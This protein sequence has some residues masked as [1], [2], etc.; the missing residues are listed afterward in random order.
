MSKELSEQMSDFL[1]LF[2]VSFAAGNCIWESLA[3]PESYISTLNWITLIIAIVAYVLPNKFLASCI[4]KDDD[5]SYNNKKYDEV[6]HYFITDYDRANPIT[7]EEAMREWFME[8][9]KMSEEPHITDPN[10]K[11]TENEGKKDSDNFL[12]HIPKQTTFS[13]LSNYAISNPTFQQMQQQTSPN[14]MMMMPAQFN[15]NAAVMPQFNNFANMQQARP[16]GGQQ[17]NP[18]QQMWNAN[19]FGGHF[20][21]PQ[22]KTFASHLPQSQ[23]QN[24]A[25]PI[26][27]QV[28]SHIP[29]QTPQITQSASNHISPANHLPPQNNNPAHHMP[30]GQSGPVMIN[31][32]PFNSQPQVIQ[33]RVIQPQPQS[34]PQGYMPSPMMQQQSQMMMQQQPAMMMQQQPQVMMQ[35]QSPMMMQPQPQPQIM[36]QQPMYQ[37]QPFMGQP[38]YPMQQNMNNQQAPPR[39]SQSGFSAFDS[40]F[41]SIERNAN[42]EK[43]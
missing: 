21:N 31:S 25:I 9:S 43:R 15:R 24:V 39:N 4:L 30:T 17:M 34:Q 35:R 16:F 37:N 11:P 36:Q 41:K 40:A 1:E 2:L 5:E 32:Q 42:G 27:P 23:S 12:K 28:S 14:P 13:N 7:Q 29:Q 33:P 18:F 38:G 19:K 20:P 8:M 22:N 10:A 26:K 3:R 6:R